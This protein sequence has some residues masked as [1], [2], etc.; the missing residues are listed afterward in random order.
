M[1]LGDGLWIEMS[2][3]LNWLH[4]GVI[5]PPLVLLGDIPADVRTEILAEYERMRKF[6]LERLRILA[7]GPLHYIGA[8]VDAL[9]EA[10][11]GT[12][13]HSS[14]NAVHVSLLRCTHPN[15]AHS[16]VW[17][18]VPHIMRTGLAESWQWRGALPVQTRG[19]D[20]LTYGTEE[21]LWCEYLDA[22]GRVSEEERRVRNGVARR[23]AARLSDYEEAGR[24]RFI[25]YDVESVLSILSV[26]LLAQ[27]AGESTL[28]DYFHRVRFS[29]DW[30]EAFRSAFGMSVEDFYKAFA[31][32]RAETFPPLPH[33]T[34]DL[35]ELVL[36]VLD[37]VPVEASAAVSGEFERVRRFF[38]DRFGAEATEVTLYV[39]QD[40]ETALAA[41]PGW[42]GGRECRQFPSFG[43]AV[44]VLERCDSSAL[45]YTYFD[46]VRSELAF[47][48]PRSPSGSTVG[49][50]PAWFDTGVE[51]YSLAMYAADTRSQPY[52]TYRDAALSAVAG[53]P[54]HL[55]RIETPSDARAVGSH[56][57]SS[58]GV[59]A[60]EWLANHAGDPAVFEYYRLLPTSR[61][62][63]A[64]FEDA[65]G[66]TID[67]FHEQF[68]AYRATLEA[69]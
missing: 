10:P 13:C 7:T 31:T 68:E 30:R 8:D 50:A 62:R 39:A 34:D 21:Y 36:V 32:Y 33:L 28:F 26:E 15:H 69:P 37:D 16:M 58:I 66:L 2:S 22:N 23:T 3:P 64:A 63:A 12:S 6:F 51:L 52:R 67:E 18:Y 54:T 20:W 35:D 14:S 27:R 40:A 49:W 4:S 44:I 25:G 47:E 46:G 65:F 42:H 41:A 57:A 56:F 19:A 61:S 24:A 11:F 45:H 53:N 9:R 1:S 59:L 17:E 38:T 55:E 5:D 48:Q 60:V 43:L 29:S